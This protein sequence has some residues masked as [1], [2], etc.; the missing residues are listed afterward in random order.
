MVHL[1]PQIT[2][3]FVPLC[4]G[5]FVSLVNKYILN[6]PKIDACC[7]TVETPEVDTDSDDSAE[8]KLSE[9]LSKASGAT[10]ATLPPPHPMHTHHAYYT[11]S[12]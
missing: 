11:H 5:L 9:T 1:P 3:S 6:T 7:S 2:D 8:S 4:A 10:T 12:N